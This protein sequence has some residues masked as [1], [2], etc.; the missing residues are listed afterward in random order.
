MYIDVL[1]YYSLLVFISYLV[2]SLF[3]LILCKNVNDFRYLLLVPDFLLHYLFYFRFYDLLFFY[4]LGLVWMP[5]KP[6]YVTYIFFLFCILLNN[7][8]YIH[9]MSFIL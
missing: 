3:F 1:F 9:S 7:I 5:L 8:D 6:I 4:F 2:V